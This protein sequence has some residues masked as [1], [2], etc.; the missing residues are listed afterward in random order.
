MNKL[1]LSEEFRRMQKLAGINENFDYDKWRNWAISKNKDLTYSDLDGTEKSFVDEISDFINKTY[2][3][4]FTEF[5]RNKYNS[6]PPAKFNKERLEVQNGLSK[7]DIED[8]SE[9]LDRKFGTNDVGIKVKKFITVDGSGSHF[10]RDEKKIGNYYKLILDPLFIKK[11]EK[12]AYK[13]YEEVSGY[14]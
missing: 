7:R 10:L 14:N 6:T 3:H 12:E 13:F 9:Y 5:N 11:Y 2:E 1:I 8:L 4:K